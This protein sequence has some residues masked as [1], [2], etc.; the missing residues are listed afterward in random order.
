V[1]AVVRPNDIFP[2]RFSTNRGERGALFTLV[3][4]TTAPNVTLTPTTDNGFVLRVASQTGDLF[5]L[6]R[7]SYRLV[8]ALDFAEDGADPARLL[9]TVE[10]PGYVR[11]EL[12]NMTGS[13]ALDPDWFVSDASTGVR[14]DANGKW[15][16]RLSGSSVELSSDMAFSSMQ[17]YFVFTT[18]SNRTRRSAETV[19]FRATATSFVGISYSEG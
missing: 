6:S 13:A 7:G 8:L 14:R 17:I 1:N 18:A 9:Q 11:V 19:A 5:Q 15:A 4:G 12:S 10:A 3:N 16:M 2:S